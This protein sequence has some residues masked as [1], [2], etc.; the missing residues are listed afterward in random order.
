MVNAMQS[1]Y[2]YYCVDDEELDRLL[3]GEE[4]DGIVYK[5][6]H[7]PSL[8]PVGKVSVL[9]D[10]TR[11]GKE[12]FRPLA[13]VCH[14][15][16][17]Q[18]LCGRY[19]HVRAE[20]SPLTAWCHLLSSA[21][22]RDL[23]TGVRDAEFGNTLA[24][25]SGLAIAETSLLAGRPLSEIRI[26]ACLA[27]A[28]F[29]VARTKALWRDLHFDLVYQRFELA[30]RICRGQEGGPKQQPRVSHVRLSFLPM[31]KCLATL[32]GPDLGSGTDELYPVTM[33]LDALR[34]ARANGEAN[35]AACLVGPLKET[36]PE[37]SMYERLPDLAPEA[38]LKLFDE[39][40]AKYRETGRQDVK[41]RNALGVASG[42]L[43]TVAAGGSSS[44][45]LLEDYADEFPELTGWAYLIGGIGE[46]VT[47]TSAFDGLGRLVARELSRPFRLD[48]PPTCDFAFDEAIVLA[49]H[50]L[51]DPLVHLR[52]KQARILNV[53]LFPGV[54]IT[55]PTID[56]TSVEARLREVEEER[57]PSAN[58]VLRNNDD[59][60]LEV[61]AN[62]LWPYMLPLVI[63]ES[64]QRFAA[65][66][67]TKATSRRGGKKEQVHGTGQLNLKERSSGKK[68]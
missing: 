28:T 45:A 44:L 42:Y 34:R 53:A 62:A 29:A 59:N 12:Q 47:W 13:L 24:S 14:D 60:V 17:I 8:L 33:G 15:E 46:Q 64:T 1:T 52:I 31:W 49:D 58:E 43:A 3:R 38:R 40:V 39:L 35:E 67:S 55:I 23:D 65:K 68:R 30:N 57:P 5:D 11:P 22:L 48:E 37:I 54:N 26:A 27:S 16:D 51:K 2:Q 19:A 7:S 36:V 20:F 18:W 63:E 10:L 61:L 32:S 4:V 21:F 56:L 66:R 9:L 50:Q 25:W 6:I 41:R